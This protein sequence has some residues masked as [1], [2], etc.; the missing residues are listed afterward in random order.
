MGMK[1]KRMVGSTIMIAVLTLFSIVYIYPVFLMFMNAFKPFG[2]VV[3]DPIAWPKQPT[4]EKLF[5]RDR[6]DQV[7]PALYE[8]RDHY[9][10]RHRRHRD[11][12]LSGGLYTGP[13]ARQI[14]EACLHH[15]HY[16]DADPRSRRS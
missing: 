4:W 10:H 6:Q 15:H 13:Q 1:K 9:G 12:L 14:H 11:L 3:S 5:V 2:E 16:A 8:Q 7:R